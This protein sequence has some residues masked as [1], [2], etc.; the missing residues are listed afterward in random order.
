MRYGL[1]GVVCDQASVVPATAVAADE[2]DMPVSTKTAPVVT[3]ADVLP[4]LSV[5]VTVYR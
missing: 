1:F 5:A 3:G 2:L 4:T